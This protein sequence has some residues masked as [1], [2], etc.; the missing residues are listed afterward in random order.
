MIYKPDVVTSASF[1]RKK[2]LVKVWWIV[3]FF[4]ILLA[5]NFKW[6]LPV[7]E[8]I[9][10]F[11]II[12]YIHTFAG[13]LKSFFLNVDDQKYDLKTQLAANS[14]KTS[15]STDISEAVSTSSSP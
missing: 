5:L 1:A 3:L 7:A 6:G 14:K 13:D 10:T 11:A 4:I 2:T 9:G 12:L 15:D 8:W